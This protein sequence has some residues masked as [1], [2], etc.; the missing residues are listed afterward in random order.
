MGEKLH[1]TLSLS[2]FLSVQD[3]VIEERRGDSRAFLFDRVLE[4]IHFTHIV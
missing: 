3:G 1:A 4:K 2:L